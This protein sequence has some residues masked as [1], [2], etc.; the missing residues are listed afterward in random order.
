MGIQET[1]MSLEAKIKKSELLIEAI[2]RFPSFHDSEVVQIILDRGEG[3]S[4][5][6]VNLHIEEHLR[7]VNKHKHN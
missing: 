4:P 5:H 7:N 3:R 2:G 6:R 1:G